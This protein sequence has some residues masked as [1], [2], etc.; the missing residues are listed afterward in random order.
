[1]KKILVSE[2]LYGGR[3]VR[4]DAGDVSETHPIFLKWKEE[5]RLIPICPEVFGG[6]PTP[7]PDSQRVGDKVI[8]CTGPDVTAEYTAGAEEALRLAK[9]NDVVFCLM[10]QDSPS[11]GFRGRGPQRRLR[12]SRR[13]PRRNGRNR[14][15]RRLGAGLRHERLVG[16]H[17]DGPR[18]R[19]GGLSRRAACRA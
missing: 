15:H 4:Y 10:K 3:I 6:L 12:H 14:A 19:R 13:R 7:R 17:R 8:A 5:R 9:E 16:R 1:M 18:R 11:C 2:C